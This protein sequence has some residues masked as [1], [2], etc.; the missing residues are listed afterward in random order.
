MLVGEQAPHDAGGRTST[1]ERENT[2][3]VRRRIQYGQGKGKTGKVVAWCCLEV[4]PK[5]TFWDLTTKGNNAQGGLLVSHTSPLM[6]G[7][8]EDKICSR[9]CTW[10]QILNV[11]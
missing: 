2:I 10:R 8:Y 1:G 3:Q 5:E 11:C 6:E 7:N 9:A 4:Q